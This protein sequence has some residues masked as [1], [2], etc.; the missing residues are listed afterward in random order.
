MAAIQFVFEGRCVW[1]HVFARRVSGWWLELENTTLDGAVVTAVQ[2]KLEKGKIPI[3]HI[4]DYIQQAL[5]FLITKIISLFS[6]HYLLY[7]D[8]SSS[9]MYVYLNGY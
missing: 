3:K 5:E 6:S 9:I 1:H 4:E 7:H 8:E 2:Q